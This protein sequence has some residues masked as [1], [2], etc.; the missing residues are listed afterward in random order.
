MFCTEC[1]YEEINNMCTAL[2]C[3]SEIPDYKRDALVSGICFRVLVCVI[4]M[5]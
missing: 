5:G 3:N 4:N 2:P 1:T